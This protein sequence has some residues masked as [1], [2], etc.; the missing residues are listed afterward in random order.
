MRQSLQQQAEAE[1][2]DASKKRR[3]EEVLLHPVITYCYHLST[4][5]PDPTDIC[6]RHHYPIPGDFFGII[7]SP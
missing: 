3:E 6:R 5:L 7:R 1:A 4:P 2:A